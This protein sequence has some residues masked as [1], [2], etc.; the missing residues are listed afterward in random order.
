MIDLR[1]TL[2]PAGK[3]ILENNYSPFAVYLLKVSSMKPGLRALPIVGTLFVARFFEV[4]ATQS[5]SIQFTPLAK[6]TWSPAPLL[7]TASASSGLPVTFSVLS[8]P[9]VLAGDNLSFSAAGIVTVRAEQA[10]NEQ[11]ASVA[12]ERSITVEKSLQ[13]IQWRLLQEPLLAQNIPYPLEATASSGLPVTFR[14]EQGPAIIE[15]GALI[16]SGT[17]PVTVVAEQSGDDRFLPVFLHRGY[18]GPDSVLLSEVSVFPPAHGRGPTMEAIRLGNYVYAAADRGG[19]HLLDVTD[20]THPNFARSIPAVRP[21]ALAQNGTNLFVVELGG[22]SIYDITNPLSPRRLGGVTIGTPTDVALSGQYAYVTASGSGFYAVRVT[23]PTSPVVVEGV[24]GSFAAKVA[25]QGNYAYVLYKYPNN[26]VVYDITNRAKPIKKGSLPLN[27][28]P[29]S[30][31]V[32]G[33]YA[34]IANQKEGLRIIDITDPTTPQLA[35]K[36]DPNDDNAVAVDIQGATAFLS[37]YSTSG[38]KRLIAID[39]TNPFGPREVGSYTP[40]SSAVGISIS[41]NLAILSEETYGIEI[42]DVSNSSQMTHLGAFATGTESERLDLSGNFAYVAEG[43][44]GLRIIDISDPALPKEASTYPTTGAAKDVKVKENLA[45]VASTGLEIVNVTDPRQPAR[46]AYYPTS[47]VK[48]AAVESYANYVLVG[49]EFRVEIVNVTDPATPRS[50]AL[51]QSGATRLHV[52]GKYAFLSGFRSPDFRVY[53][54]SDPRV[55]KL[56]LRDSTIYSDVDGNGTHAYLVRRGALIV[57]DITDVTNPVPL[58]T[59]PLSLSPYGVAVLGSLAFVADGSDGLRVIDVTFPRSPKLMAR[60][61]SALASDVKLSQN[62]AYL[63]DNIGGLRIIRY[64]VKYR[65]TIYFEPPRDVPLSASP[66]TLIA[67]ATSGLPVTFS[68]RSGPATISGNQLTLTGTG[69]VTIRARQA[70][71]DQFPV[72]TTDRIINVLPPSPKVS[73]RL[74]TA[75]KLDFSWP[76]EGASG[77]RLQYTSILTPANW[78]DVTGSAVLSGN[79]YRLQVTP[80]GNEGYFRLIK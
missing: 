46:L 45:F 27:A 76:A 42:V 5:Q 16:V 74:D 62:Y 56:V 78:Q 55:P 13:T 66:L 67:S 47:V 50:E 30:L 33:S 35:G 32:S 69:Q 58:G 71:N 39:V 17:D 80:T 7:L 24:P 37:Y 9:G 59:S 60:L 28:E 48:P 54:L 29:F 11:Y 53:D 75:G 18:N 22:L 70:G 1:L 34:Y 6:V 25:T 65:Q 14:V 61:G 52:H 19:V 15:N 79:E 43:P 38:A 57:H 8:G 21:I 40:R 77:Y 4:Y 72:W 44:A 73:V 2:Y 31:S 51:I 36:F 63:A 23:D 41:A 68:V 3:S 49:S 20:P 26:F 10:G 12:V 64:D